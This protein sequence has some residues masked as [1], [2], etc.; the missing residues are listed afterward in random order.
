MKCLLAV[1]S[2]AV[3]PLKAGLLS[4]RMFKNW[5]F[6]VCNDAREL[7]QFA[8]IRYDVVVTSRF[9]SGETTAVILRNLP[10]LFPASR[11]VL[12]VGKVDANAEAYI[13][14]AHSNRL[15]N[16]VKGLLP[17]ER[18]YTLPTALLS[19]IQE[20]VDDIGTG[21]E[22]IQAQDAQETP[23]LEA[24][25][26][27]P[28]RDT[29]PQSVSNPEEGYYRTEMVNQFSRAFQQPEMYCHPPFE[30][31][32]SSVLGSRGIVC[33][34]AANKGGVG[35]T[36]AAKT[37]AEALARAGVPTCLTDLDFGAPD[38]AA[39]Y[40][41]TIGH[42]IEYLAGKTLSRG[43]VDDV[44]VK[45]SPNLY[46]LPGP[47]NQTLPQFHPGQLSILMEFLRSRFSVV[48][49][50][51]SPEFWTK[52][53]YEE[54]FPIA[55]LVFSLVDQSVYSEHET[56]TFAPKLIG[57]GITPDK[58]RIILNRFSP[59]LHNA[60]VIEKHYCA[61]LKKDIPS[62]MLPRVAATIPEDWDAHIMAGYKGK[63]VGLED[64]Y[65]Q[66]HQLAAEIAQMAGYSYDSK[67]NTKANK[68]Q[69]LLGRLVSRIKK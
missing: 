28:V 8:P 53:W 22:E 24:I 48:I 46:V 31:R 25:Y 68:K 21:P 5:H 33:V 23:Q 41:I 66:W 39:S 65:S 14:L 27:I 62:K 9:L 59:K 3:E 18:P 51:T 55:D 60:K 57:M 1:E 29:K 67:N 30:A 7:R 56:K 36:T 16:I 11:I 44:L 42:G 45:I 6:E 32:D 69:G 26:Q 49:C 52:P 13:K 40:N 43:Y 37:L 4:M 58:I 10:L 12:V 17:G 15:Y 61:G 47:M 63:V 54:I 34:T 19:D 20:I 64:A 35:K 50:D 2:E 38:I